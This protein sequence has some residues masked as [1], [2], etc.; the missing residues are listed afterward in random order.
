[1]KH[2]ES[3]TEGRIFSPLIRFALPVLFALFLQTMYGAV[4]LLIVGQLGG[5]LADVYVSA[6]STGSQLMQAIT[7]VITGLAMGLTV[8]VGKEIGAG[9]REKAGKIIGSGIFLFGVIAVGIAV[10][11]VCTSPLL[12]KAMHAPEE[13][14]DQTVSY[15]RICSAGAVFIVAYNLVGSILE[16]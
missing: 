5:E 8:F 6:V 3:F 11:M 15:I 16:V 7:V 4:D 1:M 9:Q 14:F 13:A 12:A 10:I 2:N